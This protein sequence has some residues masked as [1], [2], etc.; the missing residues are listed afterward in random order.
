MMRGMISRCLL[1]GAALAL[2]AHA[3]PAAEVEVRGDAILVDGRPFLPRGAAGERRLDLLKSLG[4]N[5]VR[6][7]GEE[8]GAVL[9]EAQRLGL[10][11]VAGFWLEHPRRGFDYGNPA[12]VAR[13]MEALARFVR[14]YKDHP[15]LL[16]WGLGN[17]VEAELADDAVVWPAIEAAARLV[18]SIDRAHPTMAVIAEAGSDKVAKVKRLAPGIDVLGVNSYGPA[19]ASLPGRVRAQGWT[20]P[21]LI[22]EMG[23]I[24]QWQAGRAPWGAF[25]E[26]S[27]TAKAAML[28]DQLAAVMPGTQGQFVFYWGQKQEVTPTWHSLLLPSGE[29]TETAEVFAAAWGGAAPAGNRAPRIRK[30]DFEPGTR[31]TVDVGLAAK[32]DAVDPDGD[33]LSATWQVMAES[34]DLRKAGDAESVPASFPEAVRGGSAAGATVTGLPAGR[35]RLFL[36]LRDGRG[37]AATANLPF[38]LR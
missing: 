14:T 28:R 21:L 4:A 11:V 12:L 25:V 8:T 6:T 15:A 1:L 37:A 7:Y 13:Q 35:Y 23:P 10:K 36:T 2:L 30:L 27:S 5:A 32:L 19:L 26:P 31:F 29:W 9:D 24:G 3:A 18:K 33:V 17:E 16:L 34:T 22:T 38:E 20:G